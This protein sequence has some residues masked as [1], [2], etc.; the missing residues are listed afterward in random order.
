[1]LFYKIYVQFYYTFYTLL[2]FPGYTII[3]LIFNIS[4][5]LLLY[6]GCS[7]IPACGSIIS[8]FWCDQSI[9]QK[10]LL[11]FCGHPINADIYQTEVRFLIISLPETETSNSV[12]CF[13][14]LTANLSQKGSL[15]S[16]SD[17]PVWLFPSISVLP[18]SLMP[19]RM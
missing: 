5:F 6:H 2:C 7:F 12:A 19:K 8:N 13:H 17:T 15:T 14:V 3:P 11:T 1:M 10:S 9:N 4:Y 18:M 16:N